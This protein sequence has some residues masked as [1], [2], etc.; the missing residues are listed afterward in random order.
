ME[1]ATRATSPTLEERIVQYLAT[2]DSA[3]RS[4][5]CEVLGVSRTALGR[6]LATLD[7]DHAISAFESPIRTGAGRPVSY[8]RL[9]NGIAH[10]VGLNIGRTSSAGVITD[11]SGTILTSVAVDTPHCSSWRTPLTQLCDALN[12]QARSEGITMTHLAHVGVG[13]PVPMGLNVSRSGTAHF[14]TVAEIDEAVRASWDVPV[15]VENTVRMAALG[16]SLW[17]SGQG[18]SSQLYVRLSGGIGGCLVTGDHLLGGDKGFAGELGHIRLPGHDAPC[19]CGKSGCLETLASIPSICRAAGVASLAE[20]SDLLHA[21]DLTSWQT[22]SAH[23]E[24]RDA[25]LRA[26][27][28]VGRVCATAVLL[29]NPRAVIIAGELPQFFPELVERM[30]AAVHDE[31]IPSM[32]WDVDVIPARLSS[33][34]AARA[35]AVAS[36]SGHR[37]STVGHL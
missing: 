23:E 28:A 34:E 9:S 18:F 33:V 32:T 8:L 17:G 4:Q 26:A 37:V 6:A 21:E 3:T 35:A 30:A 27:D 13:V 16:E 10:S 29:F 19:P 14:P 11:R 1:Y 20:L 15:V 31:L 2:V 24:A 7:A 22:A 5:L 12:S 25:L 36:A